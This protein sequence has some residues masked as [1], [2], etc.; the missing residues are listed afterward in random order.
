MKN[1]FENWYRYLNEDPIKRIG[2][3]TYMQRIFE[4][5]IRVGIHKK[6]GGDREETFTEIRGIPGV[7]TVSVDSRG[8]SRD[9]NYYYST[10]ICKFELI[11]GQAASLYKKNILL[12]NLRKIKGL[13]LFKIGSTKEITPHE[14]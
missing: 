8:T 4:L 1:L 12:P 3:P 6:R 7:T 14:V 10:I 11:R 13:V 2:D 5:T 9:E